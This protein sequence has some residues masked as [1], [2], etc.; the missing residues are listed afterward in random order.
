MDA[1]GDGRI[2]RRELRFGLA[3]YASDVDGLAPALL[4]EAL[5]RDALGPA[6]LSVTLEAL[7]V[8]V[9]REAS[10]IADPKT[11]GDAPP[12]DIDAAVWARVSARLERPPL[13]S[14]MRSE[15]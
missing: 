5:N 12:K 13:E 8:W 14:P 2:S 9:E 1:D 10:V 7:R 11:W 3:R 4:R 15:L 6:G